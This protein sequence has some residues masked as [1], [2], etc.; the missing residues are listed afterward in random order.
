MTTAPCVP[1]VAAG[2]SA[3]WI[4]DSAM[5][6]PVP[7]RYWP[8]VNAVVVTVNVLP[9]LVSEKLEPFPMVMLP[10]YALGPWPVETSLMP[11]PCC[12]WA[13]VRMS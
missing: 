9:V 4:A 12:W 6:V 7:R 13:P 5:A 3:A 8:A 10:S 2:R 1:V 11:E